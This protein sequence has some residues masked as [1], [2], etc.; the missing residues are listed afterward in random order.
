MKI[1]AIIL[2]KD[3]ERHIGR[4]LDSLAAW[5]DYVFVVDSASTDR[6]V[7]IATGKGAF[8]VARPWRNYSD[9]LNW[10]IEN[11]PFTVDWLF[12]ID[13]DEVFRPHAEFRKCLTQLPSDVSG[14]ELRRQIHFLGRWLRH[15]GLYPIWHLRIWRRGLGKCEERWMDEHIVLQV[16]GTTRINA[17][18]LDINLNSITWWTDK[19]NRYASR[20]AIDL[21]NEDLRFMP[22]D[23]RPGGSA[24][25]KRWAKLK[26][27]RRTPAAMRAGL[28]FIYRYV[29]RLGFADGYPGLVFHALQGFWY[30]FLVDAKVAEVK[31][32]LSMSGESIEIV[33][34]RVLNIKL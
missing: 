21:L 12:R 26:I 6:T 22:I 17:E 5:V 33:I 1:A 14:V 11:C 32:E 34:E 30:R 13:A 4:C 28:Y 16:G 20:E 9:Q 15:G 24:G 23:D 7:E 19:H 8:V 3:E 29:L 10:A 27:Y 31:R 2:A 18:V 25:L